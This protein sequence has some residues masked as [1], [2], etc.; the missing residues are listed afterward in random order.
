MGLIVKRHGSWQH[1]AEVASPLDACVHRLSRR[2]IPASKPADTT[3]EAGHPLRGR[4]QRER[5]SLTSAA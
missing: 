5:Q 1:R 3:V 4:W 2:P